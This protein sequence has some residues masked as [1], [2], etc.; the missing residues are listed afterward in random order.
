M[1]AST[2]PVAAPAGGRRFWLTVAAFAL[3]NVAAWVGY[4]H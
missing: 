1:T 2:T 4:H 3:A